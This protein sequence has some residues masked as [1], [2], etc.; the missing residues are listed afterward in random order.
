MNKGLNT[1]FSLALAAVKLNKKAARSGWPPGTYIFQ[2]KYSF[3]VDDLP[4]STRQGL[5]ISRNG[6]IEKWS[7]DDE[8]LFTDDWKI[9]H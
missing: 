3:Q 7:P 6:D 2:E 4:L 9:Y 5:F 8:S 1:N